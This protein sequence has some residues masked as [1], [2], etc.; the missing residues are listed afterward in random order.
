MA[1][2]AQFDTARRASLRTSFVF[3]LFRA[4]LVLV[5]IS[6]GI[7][8]AGRSVGQHLALG[9]H[10]TNTT[11]HEIVIGDTALS[12]PAN[13]IRFPNS[14]QDGTTS[15]IHLYLHWPDMAGYSDAL[16]EEFNHVDDRRSILFLTIERQ[17]MSRDMS[18]R[19]DP[20]Y[21]QLIETPGRSGPGGLAIHEFQSGL[22]Y[23][24]EVL[25][26]SDA[27]RGTPFVARCLSGDAASISL[28]PCER[29]V[30][31]GEGLSMTYRF[32]AELAADWETLDA[33]LRRF[34]RSL[35]QP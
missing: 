25:I 14:R 13:M 10:T 34:A 12:I 17:S 20:V 18:G 26:V 16:R 22:S 29:D 8:V 27:S 6:L 19:F 5:L 23:A 21:R 2:T 33:S 24:D 9:G 31:I 4:A 7:S 15:S 32:P 1:A 3:R 28:A 30:A 11:L 35:Q